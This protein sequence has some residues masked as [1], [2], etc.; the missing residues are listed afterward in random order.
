[1][2]PEDRCMEGVGKERPKET[3][4]E[5]REEYVGA[6]EN[7]PV[8]ELQWEPP[9]PAGPQSWCPPPPL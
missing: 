1:M 9:A 3:D 7:C 2:K 5:S 6:R 4:T 8:S